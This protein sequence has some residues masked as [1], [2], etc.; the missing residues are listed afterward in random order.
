[1]CMC[2]YID[3]DTEIIDMYIRRG[4]RPSRFCGAER[5]GGGSQGEK[6]I[7]RDRDVHTYRHEDGYI[8]R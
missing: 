3:V 7:G 8:C 5:T 6:H 1:M 2:V 4:Q